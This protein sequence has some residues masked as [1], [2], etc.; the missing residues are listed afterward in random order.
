MAKNKI[1]VELDEDDIKELLRMRRER[2]E[3]E[4]VVFVPYYVPPPNFVPWF[5]IV[6]PSET[7]AVPTPPWPVTVTSDRI[8]L[9]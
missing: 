9:S 8:V 5:G 1:M 3:P 2:A 6:P 7:T 4:R